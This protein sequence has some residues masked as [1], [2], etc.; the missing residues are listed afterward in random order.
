M[1]FPFF[2]AVEFFLVLWNFLP[3]SVRLFIGFSIIAFAIP[4]IVRVVLPS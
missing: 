2:G 3:L 1:V 4:S